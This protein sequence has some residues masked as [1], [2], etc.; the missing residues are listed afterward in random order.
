MPAWPNVGGDNNAWGGELLTLLQ[1]LLDPTSGLPKL[2]ADIDANGHNINN[3]GALA[4]GGLTGASGAA[5]LVGANTVGPPISGSWLVGD[6]AVDDTGF[7]WVC[8]TAGTPGTWQC[9]NGSQLGMMSFVEGAVGD[10]YDVG[11]QVAGGSSFFLTDA[12]ELA[13]LFRIPRAM[14]I[15][16]L[17]VF[18]AV[19]GSTGS[20]VRLG[21]RNFQPSAPRTP[22]TVIVDGGTVAT[23]TNTTFS[24][25]TV[26]QAL[27]P[28]LVWACV[29]HQGA[30]TTACKQTPSIPDVR[31]VGTNPAAG[32][33]SVPIYG[34]GQTGIT[35][36]LPGSFTSPGIA[37]AFPYFAMRRSV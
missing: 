3:V 14:T 2:A 5:R 13:C 28:G 33:P 35:G 36:A 19:G 25:V 23:T 16:R 22:G 1:Q 7:T 31:V 20:V 34:V 9:T 26:N 4:A 10:Y 17:G 18:T 8:I 11:P 6:V 29:A 37:T 21:L 30:P 15:D 12:Q 27:T 24:T 32:G